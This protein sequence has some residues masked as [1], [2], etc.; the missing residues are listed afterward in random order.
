M[1]VPIDYYVLIDFAGFEDV[2]DAL[3]G[4]EI[5]VDKRMY[6]QTYDGLIDIEA[7]VQRLDCL[8]YT[9]WGE[10]RRLAFCPW[11]E[12]GVLSGV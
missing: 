7:G 12:K 8:L 6:Y 4:V 3:G 9:S 10:K 11:R 5:E 1:N 2:I